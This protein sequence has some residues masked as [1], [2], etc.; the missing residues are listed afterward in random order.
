[1]QRRAGRGPDARARP[2]GLSAERAY[3]RTT[4]PGR[5]PVVAADLIGRDFTAQAPGARLVGDITHLR[6]GEGWL[7]LA[8]VIDLATR[9]VVGWQTAAHMRT[10]LVV[11]ALAMAIRHGHVRA[12]AVFHSDR[13]AQGGF[14]RSSQHLVGE[15]ERWVLGRGRSRFGSIGVRFHRRGGRRW[16]GGRTGSSS[17][18]RSVAV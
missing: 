7:Y 3:K 9:M 4:V 17:G 16:R 11:D 18:L 2:A 5:E 1:M 10:S 13:G 8:T 14:N 12:D 15:V 6:T